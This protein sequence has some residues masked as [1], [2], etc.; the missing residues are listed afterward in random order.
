MA[1]APSSASIRS[2]FTAAAPSYGYSA[3]HAAGPDL[4]LL[5]EAANLKPSDRVIDLGTGAGHTAFAFAPHAASV[6]AVDLT[7]EMLRVGQG[8][9]RERKITNVTFHEA[10]VVRLPFPDASF[11]VASCRYC[12]HHFDEPGDALAEAARVLVPGG[13][14]LLVDT[15]AP[16][17]PALDTFVQVFEFLRDRSHVRNLRASEW[18]RLFDKH[19]FDAVVR[20]RAPIVL[21]G[22]DWVKRMQTPPEKVAMIRTLF[23]EATAA[24]KA[25]FD[26]VS[27]EPWGLSL[28]MAIVVAKK[29]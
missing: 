10:D 21:D 15:V 7:A 9:A 26:L 14:F 19:G 22:E 24:Q 13:R 29:R 11:E 18:I 12:A 5:V 6:A 3:V 28:P 17:T 20:H 2:Q 23:A 4:P 27:E 8:I 1:L 16:E 25:A